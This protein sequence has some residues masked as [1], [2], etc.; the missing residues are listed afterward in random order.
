MVITGNQGSTIAHNAQHFDNDESSGRTND[1]IWSEAGVNEGANPL[2]RSGRSASGGR[3][4]LVFN[5]IG[6][7]YVLC[8]GIVGLL[9]G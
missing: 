8:A 7:S 9:P 6:V 1:G 3:L 4:L 2:T 5:R